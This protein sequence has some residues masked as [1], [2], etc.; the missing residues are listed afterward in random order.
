MT[1]I[2]SVM[3]KMAAPCSNQTLFKAPRTR[4]V[5]VMEKT[6]GMKTCTNVLQIIIKSGNSIFHLHV[7]HESIDFVYMLMGKLHVQYVYI[8]MLCFPK[9]KFAQFAS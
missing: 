9:P 6:N 8:C 7:N 4:K 3:L 1:T 2:Y 5:Y